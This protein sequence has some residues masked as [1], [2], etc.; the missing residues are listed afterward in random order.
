MRDWREPRFTSDREGNAETPC[1]VCDGVSDFVYRCSEC[2]ADL[3]ADYGGGTEDLATARDE[4]ARFLDVSLERGAYVDEP[5]A[6]PP[7]QKLQQR[8][9]GLRTVEQVQRYLEAELALE[10]PECPRQAVIGALNR[11]KAALEGDDSTTGETAASPSLN[12]SDTSAA[13]QSAATDGG[14]TPASSDSWPSLCAHAPDADYAIDAAAG[15]RVLW[16]RA[17]ADYVAR[18]DADGAVIE[19]AAPEGGG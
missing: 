1:P 3:C 2:G 4:P 10:R 18:V 7:K 19:R 11:Q 15:E 13:R 14:T 8:I 16:C 6:M 5:E 17:C 9:R 12:T